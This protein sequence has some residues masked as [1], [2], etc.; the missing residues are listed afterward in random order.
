MAKELL[1]HR[2]TTI[3]NVTFC[4]NLTTQIR[5]SIENGQFD[6]LKQDWLDN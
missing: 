5:Q 6:K 4:L 3:H 1:F 2:L